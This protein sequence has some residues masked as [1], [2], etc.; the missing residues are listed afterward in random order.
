MPYQNLGLGL[1]NFKATEISYCLKSQGV[2]DENWCG[3]HT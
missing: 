2:S 1:E 3:E